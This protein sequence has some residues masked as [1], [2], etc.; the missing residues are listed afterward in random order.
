M[1]RTIERVRTFPPPP[2]IDDVTRR[3]F[4]IGAAG[5]LLLPAG[6]GEQGGGEQSGQTRTMKHVL[7]ET[8]V[9]V[10]PRRIVSL[11]DQAEL[12]AL[13]ALGVKPVATGMRDE[14]FLPWIRRAGVGGV[15]TF[16]IDSQAIPIEKVATCGPDL[17]IGQEGFVELVPDELGQIAPTV[18]TTSQDWRECVTQVA[19]AV[20][21]PEKGRDL[22]RQAEERIGETGE[23]L[24]AYEGLEVS[25]FYCYPGE[26]TMMPTDGMLG[27]ELLREMGLERPPSQRQATWE[28]DDRST[29]SEER[30]ELLD[31]DVIFAFDFS[32]EHGKALDELEDSPLFGR[33]EGVRNGNY[34][35]L[36][37]DEFRSLYITSILAV[38]VGL[39]VLEREITALDPEIS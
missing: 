17:I 2:E 13:M 10:N 37:F 5:L 9:P 7:G 18:A 33:L 28:G 14:E 27:A 36:D 19:D 11:S 20:G 38:P 8:E 30:L 4:L 3:E 15:E 25:M 16:P 31:A 22:L 21:E 1:T 32:E 35:R 6:C 24:A 26:I 23:R 34:V 29:I 12:A 39:E